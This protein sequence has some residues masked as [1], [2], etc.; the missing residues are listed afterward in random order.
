LILRR[1][2]RDRE[3]IRVALDERAN[4]DGNCVLPERSGAI[5]DFS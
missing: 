5:R 1:S 3:S 4:S 2:L